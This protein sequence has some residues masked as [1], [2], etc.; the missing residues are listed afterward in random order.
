[1]ETSECEDCKKSF[2]DSKRLFQHIHDRHHI[3]ICPECGKRTFNT[4]LAVKHHRKSVHNFVRPFLKKRLR[5]K[6]QKEKRTLNN[7]NPKEI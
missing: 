1:M 5:K 4:E 3:L 2:N 6:N 7:Y